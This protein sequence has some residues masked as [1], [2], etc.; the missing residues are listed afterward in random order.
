MKILFIFTVLY[1]SILCVVYLVAAILQ[2][3]PTYQ[4]S[5]HQ[6]EQWEDCFQAWRSRGKRGIVGS[7]LCAFNV[8]K[9]CG[10]IYD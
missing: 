7:T 9:I 5:L 4:A 8:L 6:D 2:V 1:V 3:M 10:R